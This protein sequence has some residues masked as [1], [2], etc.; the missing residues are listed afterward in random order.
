MIVCQA[1]RVGVRRAHLAQGRLVNDFVSAAQA[2]KR[3]GFDFVEV[4]AAHG[5][6]FDQFFCDS[7][8]LRTDEYGCQTPENRTRAL[9]LVLRAL[10]NVMGS[11]KRVAIRVS[12]THATF[13][14]Q[15]CK[16]SDPLRTYTAVV[17]HLDQFDLGYL[18][19]SEPRWNGGRDN[20]D[21][22]KVGPCWR[23]SLSLLTCLF[24]TPQGSFVC[25]SRSQRMGQVSV[26]GLCHWVVV[27]H[28]RDC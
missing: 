25:H 7:T 28:A 20:A 22:V 24:A 12:P 8:N 17:R 26:S 21:P 2:A 11:S 18:L 27:L 16:D 14:Y 15:A 23:V 5:Y 4:H 3:A 13:A 19:I 1:L 10:I 9:T 6:L